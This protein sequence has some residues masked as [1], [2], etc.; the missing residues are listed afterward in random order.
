MEASAL[1]GSAF[2]ADGLP[3]AGEFARHLLVGGDDF[4]EGVGDLAREPGPVSRKADGKISV[5]HR[6]KARQDYA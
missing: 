6:L 3:N 5:S 4:I 1:G 2:F